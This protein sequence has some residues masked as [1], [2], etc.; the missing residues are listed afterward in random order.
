MNSLESTKPTAQ[1]W[2]RRQTLNDI[3]KLS[4]GLIALVGA[5]D[6]VIYKFFVEGIQDRARSIINDYKSGKLITAE[7]KLSKLMKKFP[8]NYY[9]YNLF[10]AILAGQ[11]KM[12]EAIIY[13]EKS[14]KISPNYADAYNNLAGILADQKKYN[15]AIE[16]FQKA[17][18][19]NPNLAEAFYNLGNAFFSLNK[20]SE[21]YTLVVVSSNR[22]SNGNIIDTSGNLLTS[23][24]VFHD[25]HQYH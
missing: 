4:G 15:K 21:S 7:K 10:G 9:L 11:K 13:Y 5:R 2:H 1:Q 24:I 19:I 3:K 22:R 14:I 16:Y 8:N 25:V 18:Q 23:P 20:Y 12:D 17:I 6:S